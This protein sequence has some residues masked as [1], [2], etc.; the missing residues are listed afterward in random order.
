MPRRSTSP[1]DEVQV[2]DAV[3]VDPLKNYKFHVKIDGKVVGGFNTCSE[4]ED[5]MESTSWRS[6]D[7][8]NYKRKLPGTLDTPDV[9][10][11]RGLDL[12]GYL[13]QWWYDNVKSGDKSKWTRKDVEI[14]IFD[15]AINAS[16]I[17]NEGD[18][19]TVTKLTNCF[20][21]SYKRSALDSNGN[22]VLV[23][24]MVLAVEEP[25]HKVRPDLADSTPPDF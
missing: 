1:G 19:M 14:Y 2:T 21:N 4:I 23:E 17:E 22:D 5:N 10:L 13:R 24:T 9:T 7:N 15:P 20:P 3:V 8:K 18:Y 6:G 16:T 12:K 25:L 11:T